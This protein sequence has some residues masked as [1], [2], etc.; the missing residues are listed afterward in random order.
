ML[1]EDHSDTLTS[2]KNLAIDLRA[3]GE[4]QA[5]RELA[6]TAFSASPSG[7]SAWRVAGPPACSGWHAIG[8]PELI[9][10]LGACTGG[11]ACRCRDE[12]LP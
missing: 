3:P 9:A 8:S 12:V 5:E 1:G 4:Y 11:K 7:D 10:M 6:A 2:A